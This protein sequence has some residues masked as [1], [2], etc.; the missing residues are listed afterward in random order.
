MVM[1]V[2]EWYGVVWYGMVWYGK[3]R[4]GMVK[5]GMVQYGMVWCGNDGVSCVSGVVCG[6]AWC[7]TQPETQQ[8]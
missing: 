7:S 2:C 3:V 5:Y 6:V 4:D 1:M 8:T